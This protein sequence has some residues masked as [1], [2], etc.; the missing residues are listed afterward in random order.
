MAYVVRLYDGI[1]C[2]NFWITCARS[3]FCSLAS[4]KQP[5]FFARHSPNSHL[6]PYCVVSHGT[7]EH[8]LQ[9]QYTSVKMSH[10]TNPVPL[11]LSLFLSVFLSLSLSVSLSLP[12]SLF[13]ICVTLRQN[14]LTGAGLHL[15]TDSCPSCIECSSTPRPNVL[16]LETAVAGA[17][18]S[19]ALRPWNSGTPRGPLKGPLRS[20]PLQTTGPQAHSQEWYSSVLEIRERV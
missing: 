20:G 17:E 18:T 15:H 14:R 6:Q 11:S 10:T 7:L 19:E 8:H 4:H 12:P 1:A 2:W 16:S 3:Q 9:K 5:F 13:S